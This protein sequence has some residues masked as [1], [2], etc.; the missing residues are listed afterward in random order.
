MWINKGVDGR[1]WREELLTGHY[2]DRVELLFSDPINLKRDLCIFEQTADWA[3]AGDVR[4]E[5]IKSYVTF[6]SYYPYCLV[7]F[8]KMVTQWLNL[9]V[10]FSSS[11]H[12]DP[13]DIGDPFSLTSD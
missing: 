9:G 3:Q 8:V 10:F 2:S 5:F 7:Y 6:R 11:L 4:L 13:S 1:E 12:F